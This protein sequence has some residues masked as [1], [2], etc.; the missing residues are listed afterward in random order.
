LPTQN[1]T[2][3]LWHQSNTLGGEAS[4]FPQAQLPHYNTSVKPEGNFSSQQTLDE[5]L[6]THM[7]S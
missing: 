2:E 6:A 5:V 1:N 7:P 4:P 3:K